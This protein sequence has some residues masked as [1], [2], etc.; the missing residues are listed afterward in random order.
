M[1]PS[2]LWFTYRT[3]TEVLFLFIKL[4]S[5]VTGFLKTGSDYYYFFKKEY[6]IFTE[7]TCNVSLW[8]LK[9]LSQV[10]G[11]LNIVFSLQTT[12]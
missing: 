12:A 6:L 5:K 8:L 11:L 2:R 9:E 3:E 7:A 1:F 10:R 4:L